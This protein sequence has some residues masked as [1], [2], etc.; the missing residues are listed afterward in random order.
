MSE[1]PNRAPETGSEACTRCPGS[2]LQRLVLLSE[3]AC[4]LHHGFDASSTFQGELLQ[5]R[6]AF[7]ECIV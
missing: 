4:A 6:H 1:A 3:I 2:I 5:E 7:R